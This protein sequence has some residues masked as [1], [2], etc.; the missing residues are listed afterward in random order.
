MYNIDFVSTPKKHGKLIVSPSYK[1]G[2][3]DSHSVD[4]PFLFSHEGKF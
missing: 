4:C 1:E 2:A 3:F